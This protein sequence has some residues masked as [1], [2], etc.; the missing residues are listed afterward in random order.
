MSSDFLLSIE[1]YRAT[2][3]R[4][5]TRPK[6]KS[7]WRDIAGQRLFFR[8]AWEANYARYLQFQK[9]QKLIKD[10][11]YE[12]QTFWFNAIKRGVRSYL[13]DFQV[14]LLDDT[15]IWHEVKGYLD[16]KSKTKLNRMRIY[17]PD[18]RIRVIDKTWFKENSNLKNF[19]Q[20]WE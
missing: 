6:A 14:F 11:L 2:V 5:R 12:P 4:A 7:G 10:W 18:E 15:Y 1:E 13:P 3:K 9:E 16:A 17:Y 8:S 19:I 20:E